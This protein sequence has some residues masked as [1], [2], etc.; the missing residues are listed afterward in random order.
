MAT[1]RTQGRKYPRRRKWIVARDAAFARAGHTCEIS[2]EC[3]SS[4]HPYKFGIIWDRACDHL[5]PERF[6]RR[7]CKA[8]NPHV[9]ENLF[10]ITP[11]LHAKK[12]A[13]EKHI[14]KGDF[15]RYKQELVRLGWTV[16]QI[17][18]ALSAIV[19]SVPEKV[20]QA[21]APKPRGPQTPLS[22]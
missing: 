21:D 11:G 6:V 14:Y 22:D 2:G 15:L 5:F 18:R 4:S 19:K 10:V 1:A 12:T 7:F 9:G 17:D 13:V 16:E 20:E 8:A 3:L